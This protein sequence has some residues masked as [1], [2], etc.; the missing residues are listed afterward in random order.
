[1]F[2]QDDYATLTRS[3]RKSSVRRMVVKHLATTIIAVTAV[4]LAANYVEAKF[5]SKN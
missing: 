2:T 3:Q 1:M 5:D 4:S